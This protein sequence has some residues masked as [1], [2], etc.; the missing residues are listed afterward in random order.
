M[1]SWS[2]KDPPK[3][4]SLLQG[5]WASQGRATPASLLTPCNSPA[6]LPPATAQ[7]AYPLQLPS[8]R[9]D[10]KSS[11]LYYFYLFL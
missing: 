4:A 7:L 1:N 2:R 3:D 5:G 6:C 9:G 8:Q 10:D 11:H